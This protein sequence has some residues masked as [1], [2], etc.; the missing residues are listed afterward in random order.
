VGI[1]FESELASIIRV[2]FGYRYADLGK[3]TLGPF[4][5]GNTTNT[6]STTSMP[7]QEL[8]FQVTIL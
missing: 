5:E 6:I 2:G 7:T 1:G 8:I 3:V 4:D